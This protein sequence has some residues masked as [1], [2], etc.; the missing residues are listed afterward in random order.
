MHLDASAQATISL[1]S[2]RPKLADSPSRKQERRRYA[3][4]DLNLTASVSVEEQAWSGRC[5][6]LSAGGALLWLDAERQ[7]SDTFLL[8]LVMPALGG[9]VLATRGPLAEATCP[10]CIRRSP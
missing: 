7:L 4:V 5:T 3:R 1:L 9:A 8:H 2:R 6:N 10:C